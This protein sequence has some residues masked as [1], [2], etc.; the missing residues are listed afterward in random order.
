MWISARDG[1]GLDLLQAPK[2][3][4]Y[5]AV[6]HQFYDNPYNVFALEAFAK[7]LHPEAF[8]DMDPAKDF[9][10]FHADWLPFDYSGAF[11]AP[12]QQ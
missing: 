12:A 6:Y 1:Q 9:E 2:Q 7:W 5:F 10:Q 8:A 11:L 3:G 4:K